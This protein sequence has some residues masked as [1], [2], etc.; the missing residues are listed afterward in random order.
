[1]SDIIPNKNFIIERRINIEKYL[2]I[3][4]PNVISKLIS[5]Y[6]YHIEGQSYIFGNHSDRISCLATFPDGRIISGS[7]DKTIKVW[8]VNTNPLNNC[9]I[10]FEDIYEISC[11]AILNEG[12]SNC[13]FAKSIERVDRFISGSVG[14]TIK[15][16]NV[17]TRTCDMS[18]N[19]RNEITS[20]DIFP[21]GQILVGFRSGF[22][23]VLLT[24]LNPQLRKCDNRCMIECYKGIHTVLS[25]GKLV[26]CSRYHAIDVYDVQTLDLIY[27]HTWEFG[28]LFG[29]GYCDLK[30]LCKYNNGHIISV[31]Q[32]FNEIITKVW[33]AQTRNCDI[34][35]ILYS[36]EVFFN[37]SIDI[38]C[39]LP[40]NRI[41]IDVNGTLKIIDLQTKKCDVILAEYPVS[42]I[43]FTNEFI[44]C[45]AVC[46]DGRIITGS[47]MGE[48]KIWS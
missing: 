33:D 30:N 17:Q 9:D 37:Y 2:K 27:I 26:V 1:M 10:V 13:Y 42:G 36:M 32:E 48:L 25:N 23:D 16:W 29:N 20:I 7:E 3:F 12:S 45:I 11:I 5:D 38:I 24:I 14:G 35:F 43:T 6:D 44:S 41:I 47:S 4:F 39:V 46:P 19:F 40:D 31:H 15:M 21:N 34:S 22:D 28:T 8:N 18:F